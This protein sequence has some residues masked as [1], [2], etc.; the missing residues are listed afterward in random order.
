MR[1]LIMEVSGIYREVVENMGGSVYVRDL[2]KNILYINP[3]S[4]KL[5]GWSQKEA[6]GKKCYEV[7]GDE[8]LSCRDVCPVEK[9]IS[10]RHH[11]LHHEGSL[12]TRS[13]EIHKMQVS[14]SP[15]YEG[16]TIAGAV[17]VMEDITRLREVETTQA[18]TVVTLER[19]VEKS[20]KIEEE[21]RDSEELFKR[22]A[23]H[24][25]MPMAVSDIEGKIN[26]L[27]NKFSEVF[28]YT[29]QD[30]PTFEQWSNLAY[31]N[32]E[33]AELV[34]SEWFEAVRVARESGKQAEPRL[35]E[36]TCKDGT[37]RLIE[38]KRT[39]IGDQV[40]HTLNDITDF[41][42]A[43]EA[44]RESEEKYRLVVENAKEAI[45]ILQGDRI[46]F[47]NRPAIE[48]T[49]YSEEELLSTPYSE[50]VFPDDREMVRQNYLLRLRGE[51]AP[52]RYSFRILRKHDDISWIEV[53]P[54]LLKWEGK[55]ALLVF[56]LDITERKE[57]EQALLR[58][59]EDWERTFDAVPDLIMILDAE[60]RI[61]RAN[62]TIE[63]AL[64]VT[65]QEAIGTTCYEVF[66]RENTPPA[67]CPHTKLL[68]D[69][70]EHSAEV[71]VK[72]LDRIFDVTVSPLFDEGGQL[73][74]S[75]HIARD[76]TE[77]KRNERRIG[78]SLPLMRHY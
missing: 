48:Q 25:P 19:E 15:I 66:H 45:Y 14:I 5:T 74:G 55:S 12:K 13:G 65:P 67:Y 58:A 39:V 76:V 41:K 24:S 46:Q 2:E 31:P 42:R 37:I 23:D 75:V 7:F 77:K 70:N 33:Y 63:D 71:T 36:V 57:A 62:K 49:G 35:R 60:H 51:E 10:Q 22:F 30:I 69:G 38:F 56:A 64:G 53:D 34:R 78:S 61:V 68:S 47:A 73:T 9:A 8:H 28:G 4:E 52:R 29:L 59:K 18:K 27:N 17:V 3:A 20:K 21:L 43:E 32:R 44:L 1:R 11:I 72:R 26:Y 6:L 54:V 40:I 16:E 50:F